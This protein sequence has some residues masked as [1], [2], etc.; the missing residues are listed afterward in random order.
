MG[1]SVEELG[2]A[3][4]RVV[5]EPALAERLREGA[6]RRAKEQFSKDVVVPRVE[7]LYERV[8]KG[9]KIEE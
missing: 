3:L 7:A 6:R 5:T 8:V 1:R 2:E 9:D 4:R